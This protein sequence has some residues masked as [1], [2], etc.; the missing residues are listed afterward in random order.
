MSE[1]KRKEI[2]KDSYK[3]FDDDLY[4]LVEEHF[5]LWREDVGDF[6]LLA[7]MTSSMLRGTVAIFIETGGELETLKQLLEV[8]WTLHKEET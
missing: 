5:M 7:G 6:E 3:K 2:T 1:S 4:K 8:A